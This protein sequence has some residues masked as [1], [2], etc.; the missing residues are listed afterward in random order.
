[1]GEPHHVVTIRDDRALLEAALSSVPSKKRP[2]IKT[3]HR[4]ADHPQGA[5][6]TARDGS[7]ESN[8][9]HEAGDSSGSSQPYETVGRSQTHLLEERTIGMLLSQ[10]RHTFIHIPEYEESTWSAAQSAPAVLLH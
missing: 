2:A 1:M 3:D 7:S 5:V 6:G 4:A 10:V 8:E 9:P